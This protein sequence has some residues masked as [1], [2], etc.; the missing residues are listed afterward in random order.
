MNPILHDLQNKRWIWTA[1]NAK[2]HTSSAKLTSGF[3][4]LDKVLSGGFPRA[5]M[6]H[7]QSPLGCGEMRLMLSVLQNQH[8]VSQEHKLYMFIDP[9]FELNA[10]FLLAQKIPL[11]QLVI[12][13][14]TQ[15][16]DALW[17]A[18]QSAK[19]GACHAVFMWQQ[20]LKHIQVRKLEHAAQQGNSYCIWL[21]SHMNYGQAVEQSNLPLSL[22]LSISREADTLGIKINKQ[23]IGWAQNTVKIPFPFNSLTN[24]SLKQQFKQASVN[25]TNKVVPI[26]A[27]R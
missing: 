27:N 23:K 7:L 19:S 4:G 17:S 16:Q 8:E 14:T 5:G 20:H 3:E 12:V 9:P 21:H 24:R 22:S 1:A 6:I 10:E 11:T 2:Q 13:R 25:D 18:E 26:H 15:Q